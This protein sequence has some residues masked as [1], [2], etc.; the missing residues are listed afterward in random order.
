M[1]LMKTS[2]K[3]RELGIAVVLTD[4]QAWQYAQFLKRVTFADY[5][6]RATSDDEAY[7]MIAAGECLRDALKEKGYAPR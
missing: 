3:P 7:V 2:L 4:V 5:R 1:K 6:Q